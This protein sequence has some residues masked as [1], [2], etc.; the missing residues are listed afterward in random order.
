[1]I[2]ATV[3]H[4]RISNCVHT[5][6]KPYRPGSTRIEPG[7]YGIKTVSTRFHPYRLGSTCIDPHRNTC[8]FLRILGATIRWRKHFG[9]VQNFCASQTVYKSVLNP[10]RPGCKT[11]SHPIAQRTM[12]YTTRINAV[13]HCGLMRVNAV[14]T[15]SIRISIRNQN[16]CKN[17][18]HDQNFFPRR[19]VLPESIRN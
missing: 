3:T 2:Y 9:N 17:F 12:Q 15:G 14:R 13:L 10:Y 18:E 16:P 7:P 11:L 19:I 1:M 8:Q 4:S 5:K 6:L